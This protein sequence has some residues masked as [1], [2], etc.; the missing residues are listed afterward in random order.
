MMKKKG[1]KWLCDG[2]RAGDSRFFYVA[3]RGIRRTEKHDAGKIMI[4]GV[5]P[6]DVEFV[7][8]SRCDDCTCGVD[9]V[10]FE[11]AISDRLIAHPETVLWA[12]YM[13]NIIARRLGDG[14]RFMA[15]FEASAVPY[16]RRYDSKRFLTLKCD[17]GGGPLLDSTSFPEHMKIPKGIR[18]LPGS[19]S[20]DS[21]S[22]ASPTHTSKVPKQAQV[23][24][25]SSAPT[26][27]G[28]NFLCLPSYV[29]PNAQFSYPPTPMLHSGSSE[30]NF[31]PEVETKRTAPANWRIPELACKSY[32]SSVPVVRSFGQNS[33]VMCWTACGYN[34]DA[35]N[36]GES[37]GRFTK[38]F[39]NYLKNEAT[40]TYEGL[41]A[42]LFELFDK[43]HIRFGKVVRQI[44]RLY[45]ATGSMDQRNGEESVL[46]NAFEL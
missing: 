11:T 36:D 18:G 22:E 32:A 31:D 9:E 37:G 40:P 34:E 46:E 3:G 33:R 39:V 42:H 2:S 16:S 30:S 17:N 7:K 21:R 27:L 6:Y 29:D 38:A 12:H 25:F 19:R 20:V 44:P 45:M 13:N 1:I 15:V 35:A 4:E 24:D 8:Y 28:G 41:N 23:H 14:A 5:M 10:N 26:P 43:E